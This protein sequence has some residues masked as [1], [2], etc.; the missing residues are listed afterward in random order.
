MA[1]RIVRKISR[2]KLYGTTCYEYERFFV[3]IPSKALDT[4]RPWLEHDLKVQVEPFK[5]GF[6]IL[7]YPKDKLLGLYQ[8][9]YRFRWLLQQIEKESRIRPR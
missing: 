1:L 4:V 5:M 9:S 3:P 8:L 6:A 2:K 7:V